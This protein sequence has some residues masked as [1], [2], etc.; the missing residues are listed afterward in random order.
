MT[1][2]GADIFRA[3]DN[4]LRDQRIELP[5]LISLCAAAITENKKRFL[6]FTWHKDPSVICTHC[7]INRDV[8]VVKVWME[9]DWAILFPYNKF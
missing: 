3:G 9:I 6:I 8:I 1:T 5:D 7:F 2:P 4:L